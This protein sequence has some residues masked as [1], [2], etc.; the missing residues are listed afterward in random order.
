MTLSPGERL[1]QKDLMEDE[2]R[3]MAGGLAGFEKSNLRQLEYSSMNLLV[4]IQKIIK[5]SNTEM[6]MRAARL[7]TRDIKKESSYILEH[8]RI[9]IT[10]Q[11]HKV[12]GDRRP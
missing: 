6:K 4:Y 11:K 1:S 2:L 12:V 10:K 5:L 8:N 9:S 7:K 3:L